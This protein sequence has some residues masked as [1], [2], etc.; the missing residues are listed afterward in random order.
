VPHGSLNGLGEPNLYTVWRRLSD[1]AT[2]EVIGLEWSSGPRR[3]V[4]SYVLT[5]HPAPDA[6]NRWPYLDEWWRRT[7]ARKPA[8]VPMGRWLE[9]HEP[10]P[11][12][13][14]EREARVRSN[15][16]IQLTLAHWQ[17]GRRRRR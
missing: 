12:I 6:F 4:R 11:D 8:R 3:G 17:G 5:A 13:E 1:G 16:G 15:A 7:D 14:A 9:T 2:R 10:F